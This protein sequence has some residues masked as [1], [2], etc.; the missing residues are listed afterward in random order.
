MKEKKQKEVSQYVDE[1]QMIEF[2]SNVEDFNAGFRI[3]HLE[4]TLQN[5]KERAK[6][7]NF[8]KAIDQF[9][10]DFEKIKTYALLNTTTDENRFQPSTPFRMAFL[11]VQHENDFLNNLHSFLKQD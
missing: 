2:S 4:K 11:K 9:M 7:E 8:K 5:I 3:L 1:S 10:S 6:C